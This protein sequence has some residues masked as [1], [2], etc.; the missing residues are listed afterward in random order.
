L[1]EETEIEIDQHS[2][3][4]KPST[5]TTTTTTTT[6]VTTTCAPIVESTVETTKPLSAQNRNVRFLSVE[7]TVAWHKD[8]LSWLTKKLRKSAYKKEPVVVLTHHSPIKRYG[9]SAPVFWSNIDSHG[10]CT[11]LMYMMTDDR[12]TTWIYGHTHWFHDMYFEGTHVISNPHGYPIVS[13]NLQSYNH[14]DD[15]ANMY[16]NSFVVDINVRL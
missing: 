1:G 13:E 12:I 6:T 7:D 11:D 5:T 9:C 16:N 2:H 15:P 3:S 4:T 14:K 10:F 8:E